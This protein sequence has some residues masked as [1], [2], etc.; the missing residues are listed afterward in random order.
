MSLFYV[1]ILQ[2]SLS[3]LSRNVA[4][5]SQGACM[6]LN[7]LPFV[8]QCGVNEWR[9]GKKR[10]KAKPHSFSQAKTNKYLSPASFP[11][12]AGLQSSHPPILL[13]NHTC[14]AEVEKNKTK[15]KAQFQSQ[16]MFLSLGCHHKNQTVSSIKCCVLSRTS[17]LWPVLCQ[18]G[19]IRH[20]SKTAIQFVQ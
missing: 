2:R 19:S 6:E 15:Q 8:T 9:V 14:E 4:P 12:A 7:E 3:S 20:L 5:S 17:F 13:L 11:P 18:F 16:V 1:L 10:E